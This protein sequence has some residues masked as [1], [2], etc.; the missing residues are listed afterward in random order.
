MAGSSKTNSIQVTVDFGSGN[1]SVAAA[2]SCGTSSYSTLYVNLIC[3]GINE[4]I[5]GIEGVFPNPFT[6]QLN[7]SLEA[8]DTV[9]VTDLTGKVVF[10]QKVSA[11]NNILDFT[12]Y[13]TGFYLIK[14]QKDPARSW[15]VFKN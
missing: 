6:T 9:E 11:G 4:I 13:D 14:A 8:P 7:L 15:K 10:I 12:G 3:I 1:I 2:N 5:P